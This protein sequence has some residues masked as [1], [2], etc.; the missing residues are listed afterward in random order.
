LLRWLTARQLVQSPPF[1]RLDRPGILQARFG[2]LVP[3]FAT[4][5]LDGLELVVHALP[6]SALVPALAQA[7]AVPFLSLVRVRVDFRLE[8]GIHVVDRFAR[9]ARLLHWSGALRSANPPRGAVVLEPRL[10]IG[11]LL[12]KGIRI[13]THEQRQALVLRGV[14]QDQLPMLDGWKRWLHFRM[15]HQPR[16]VA[17][18]VVDDGHNASIVGGHR[19]HVRARQPA[20]ART[21][22]PTALSIEQVKHLVVG[23][24]K[25]R[26]VRHRL[27]P[28][29][30]QTAGTVIVV[31]EH[32]PGAN[33]RR[34]LGRR[35]RLIAPVLARKRRGGRVAG[36]VAEEEVEARWR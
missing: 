15:F 4:P 20:V 6:F 1:A 16:W 36:E 33:V 8:P 10:L 13:G 30:Q 28:R 9:V 18:V 7:S 26:R 35:R 11:L 24:V 14:G 31:E 12:G 29:P 25:I 34:V 23:R 27:G 21:P 2:R 5:M 32:D 3:H 19:A 22:A 17:M